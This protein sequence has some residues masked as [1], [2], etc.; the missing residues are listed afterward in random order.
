MEG[1]VWRVGCGGWSRGGEG[2]G[3]EGGSV[4]GGVCRVGC[5]GWSRGVEGGVGVWRVE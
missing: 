2:V 5:G 4:E 1:G 3:V